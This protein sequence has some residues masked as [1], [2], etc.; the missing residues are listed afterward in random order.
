MKKEKIKI[1]LIEDDLIDQMA[2]QRFVKDNNLPY[3]YSIAGSAAQAKEILNKQKF[4]I[5]ITDYKLGDGTA[6]DIFEYIVDTP[7]IFTTGAGDEKIAVKAMKAG[8]FYYHIKD[9]EGYYLE[10]LPVSI[11]KAL[12]NKK[13][14]EDQRKA[15]EALKESEEKF[16][17]IS[18]A[19]ND[20]I[21]M[22]NYQ[23]EV[24]FWNRT[25]EKIFGYN[26]DEIIG[27]NLH[28]LIVP[29]SSKNHY[30]IS[31]KS[32]WETGTSSALGKTIEMTVLNKNKQP[33]DIELSLSAVKIEKGMNQ[34]AIIRDITERKKAD[35][36]LQ[37]SEERYRTLQGNI[38]VGIYRS[39]K[40]GKF[41]SAN[42]A[43]VKIL[44]FESKEELFNIKIES[45]YKFPQQRNRFIDEIEAK[46]S[47]TAYELQLLRKDR[48]PF[49]A[50]VTTKK[51]INEDNSIYYDGIIEDI[52]AQKEAKE[53]LRQNKERLDHILQNIGNGVMVINSNQE[54]ILMNNR[55]IE[56]LG[57]I[58]RSLKKT[59]LND[60]LVNCKD[61]GKIL[62]EAL[63]QSYFRNLELTVEIP[64]LRVLYV[65]A[66]TFTD[67]DGK[68]AGK[69]FILADVTREKEIENMKTTFVS[70]VSH[71]LRTPITSIIGFS[72]TMLLNKNI[73][74]ETQ[75]EFINI[76]YKESK[77]L[78]NLIEDVLSISRIES[79]QVLYNFKAISIVPIIQDV[80]NIYKVQAEE[81]GIKIS[82]EIE[83]DI[84]LIKAD[85]D[86][87]YQIAINLIGNA[88]KFIG[89]GGQILIQLKQ[90]NDFLILN[91]ED[92]GLGIP[93]KDQ[94]KIFDRFFRVNRPRTVI[95][96]TGLGL[97]I[98]KEMVRDHNG[99]IEV[100]SQEGKGTLFKIFFPVIKK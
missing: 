37:E 99:R 95:Q 79:G 43:M 8:A 41:L 55:T 54:L 62:L 2:F 16:R 11:Q 48:T 77:R 82:C 35:L 28:S 52:T 19:A 90:E 70:S 22:L 76:I 72:K 64:I 51:I 26:K 39:S 45:I 6:F 29:T 56:L 34:I 24:V 65:T 32:Q 66:T 36:A 59:T 12:K 78:S 46:G 58:K 44:G 98:V 73:N 4:D 96:G 60:M 92:T 5:V 87:I 53:Q 67:I 49:W 50:A 68:S 85:N 15:E 21:I 20:A 71:E 27:K 13:M 74:D 63:N 91:I 23:G 18:S 38:P 3:D 94:K 17:A 30:F 93:K 9:Q 69:I 86:S 14:E 84:P 80:F 89:K 10:L 97:S 57:F 25:A 7:F 75:N 81:K 100:Y 31:L 61:N 47:V 33:L 40:K 88:L 1:L 42:P 83:K